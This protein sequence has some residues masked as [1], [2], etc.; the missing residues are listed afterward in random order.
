MAWV[1][2]G[3][4]KA[5]A[6]GRAHVE[7]PV[8]VCHES[9]GRRPQPPM[10]GPLTRQPRGLPSQRE[11]ASLRGAVLADVHTRAP[12]PPLAPGAAPRLQQVRA[13]RLPKRAGS[14]LCVAGGVLSGA[15]PR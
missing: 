15:H 13:A 6:R 8:L 4:L 1:G 10:D 14:A 9:G 2:V 7:G 11:E 3:A 12:E 5:L